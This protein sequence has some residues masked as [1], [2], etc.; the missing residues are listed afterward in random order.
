[1]TTNQIEY[2]KLL[3]TRRNNLVLSDLTEK[4]DANTFLLGQQNLDETR[5]ANQAREQYNLDYLD[6]VGRANRAR[7]SQNERSLREQERANLAKEM[8][9]L[10]YLGEVSRSNLANEDERKRSNLANEQLNRER[11][12]SEDWY[13][14]QQ[15]YLGS[16]NIALGYS[17]LEEQR[18]SNTARENETYRA[19]LAR[20]VEQNRANVAH[21]R[22]SAA[23]YLQNKRYQED[24]LE[25]TKRSNLAKEA[26][27][28]RRNLRQEELTQQSNYID[29]WRQGVSTFNSLVGAYDT[30]FDNTV[31]VMKPAMTTILGGFFK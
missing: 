24:T 14:R 29:M 13:R 5:R 3:E 23:N 27:T 20:E 30:V 10:Q 25:E 18:R 21:E 19:N 4:R 26:E 1:M 17:Q 15:V 11:L 22:L 8:Y 31:G 28:N 2:A 6:E 7:E 9:N 16:Q 12:S